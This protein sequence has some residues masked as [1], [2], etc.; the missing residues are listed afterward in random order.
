MNLPTKHPAM[1]GLGTSR[2]GLHTPS[3]VRLRSAVG[4]AIDSMIPVLAGDSAIVALGL[5]PPSRQAAV[6]VADASL[7]AVPAHAVVP[8][9]AWN[10][11]LADRPGGLC[12]VIRHDR[13]R[14]SCLYDSPPLHIAVSAVTSKQAKR[15]PVRSR[16]LW[17]RGATAPVSR[18]APARR[19]QQSRLMYSPMVGD[20]LFWI[21]VYSA[22]R[23][24]RRGE[25]LEAIK[26]LDAARAKRL[27]PLLA[28]VEGVEPSSGLR[29]FERRYPHR[30]AAIGGT[31]AGYDTDACLEALRRTI[32]SYET[33]FAGA[34]FSPSDAHAPIKDAVREAIDAARGGGDG[35]LPRHIETFLAQSMPR[36]RDHSGVVG[37]AVHGSWLRAPT[38]SACGPIDAFSDLDLIVIVEARW[39]DDRSW[40][41]ALVNQLGR[42]CM[43]HRRSDGSVAALY[44]DPLI[45]VDVTFHSVDSLRRRFEDPAILWERGDDVASV[46][47]ASQP[48]RTAHSQWPQPRA[49]WVESSFWTAMLG[50]ATRLHR[51]ELLQT[52]ADLS[53]VRSALLGPLAAIVRAEP[54]RGLRR[55]ESRFPD[56]V[57]PF[58]ATVPCY[59]A[60]ACWR[61]IDACIA[62]HRELRGCL[63]ASAVF[64]SPIEQPIIDWLDATDLSAG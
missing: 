26:L 18:V 54:C 27:A 50:C 37:A 58:A 4:H 46:L 41:L 33:L 56:L 17:R 64:R 9:Q 7:H 31:V 30:I 10:N 32:D 22:V 6:L 44:C 15:M 62:L 21:L 29:W 2:R 8:S 57:A 36:L 40:Q 38:T 43:A 34:T 11:A 19:F 25:L 51:G 63:P 39:R 49:A 59:D 16:T 12:R 52:I 42:C 53:R 61:A 24:C 1:R 60:P 35:C 48:D 47:A 13:R 45:H 20:S 28:T 23:K 14:I 5:A 3:M 55:F